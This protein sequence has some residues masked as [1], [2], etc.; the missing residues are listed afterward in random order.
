MGYQL[1]K[2]HQEQTQYWPF[3]FASPASL[4]DLGAG[5]LFASLAIA[6]SFERSQIS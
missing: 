6:A 3:P 4:R 1:H 5:G 2:K